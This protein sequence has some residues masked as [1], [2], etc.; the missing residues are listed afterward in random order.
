MDERFSKMERR[1]TLD[2]R[3]RIKTLTRRTL[4][5]WRYMLP[6]VNWGLLGGTNSTK[7]RTSGDKQYLEGVSRLRAA[8]KQN[9][10]VNSPMNMKMT[11][12]VIETLRLSGPI[13]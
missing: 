3:P 4:I 12:L 9:N 7:S 11:N 1:N 2:R 10:R 8:Y 6:M 5:R 13:S